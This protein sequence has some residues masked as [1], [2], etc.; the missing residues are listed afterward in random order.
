MGFI[1]SFVSQWLGT[2]ELGH[3]FVPDAKLFP[4]YANDVELQADIGMQPAVFFHALVSN[5]ESILDLLDSN[6]TIT[7][8]KLAA[9][10]KLDIKLR[11]D[12]QEQP[13]RCS[14]YHPSACR[15]L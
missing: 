11:G 2:R 5:N 13:H 4:N 1:N 6:W 9:L 8:K 3:E 12:N 10:Y 15:I 7:T 14:S